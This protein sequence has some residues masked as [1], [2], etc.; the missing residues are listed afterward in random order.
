MVHL[1]VSISDIT[2]Y[3][4][5]IALWGGR[6]KEFL[7]SIED[8]VDGTPAGQYISYCSVLYIYCPVGDI[9][10]SYRALRTWWMVH[11]QVSISDIVVYYTFIALWEIQGIPTKH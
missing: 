1:Q 6:Y 9:R 3:Y 10:N 4:T 5:F 2:V 7:Q 8:M 11:L